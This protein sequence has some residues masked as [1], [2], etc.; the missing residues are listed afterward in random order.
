M[1]T[2]VVK[3]AELELVS[4]RPITEELRKLAV[5]AIHEARHSFDTN[6]R[7]GMDLRVRLEL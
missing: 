7:P 3:L 5:Q 6:I 4:D 1:P 2:Y